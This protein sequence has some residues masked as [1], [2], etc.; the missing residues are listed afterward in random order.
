MERILTIASEP[1]DWVLDCFAGSGTTAAVAH[2]LGRRWV[3]VEFLRANVERYCLPRLT[4]V[5][6]GTDPGGITKSAGWKG[7]GG[8]RLMGGRA[9]HVRGSR[10]RDR[11]GGLGGRRRAGRGH[12]PPARIRAGAGRAFRRSKGSDAPGR[13]GRDREPRWRRSS[14]PSSPRARRCSSAGRGSNLRSLGRFQARPGSSAQLIP[15][16]S[17][18]SY[19]RPRRGLPAR[20][21]P[22][23]AETGEFAPP[24]AAPVDGDGGNGRVAGAAVASAAET[25]A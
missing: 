7:G 18:N 20:S 4:K 10:G 14:W 17:L 13:G 22:V 1:D 16:A 5:V 25:K 8:F 9:L 12:S 21:K 19:A 3:T 23:S 24:A 15:A 2:K 6:E 11:P